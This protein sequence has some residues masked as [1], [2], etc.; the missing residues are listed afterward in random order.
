MAGLFLS[1]P[2]GEPRANAGAAVGVL[3]VAA[4]TGETGVGEVTYEE[5]LTELRCQGHEIW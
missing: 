5:V 2:Y 1:G 4:A 3:A